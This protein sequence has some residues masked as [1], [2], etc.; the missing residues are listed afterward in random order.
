MDP[1][2]KTRSAWGVDQSLSEDT[3]NN[4]V[5]YLRALKRS[6]QGLPPDP[7]FPAPE[8]AAERRRNTR[9]KCEGSAEIYAGTSGVR[10]WASLTDLSRSGC[11]LELQATSP[12]ET[13]LVMSVELRG[14]RFRVKGI[15]RM[16]YPFLGMGVAFAEITPKD[17]ARLNELLLLLASTPTI[18]Q[19]EPAQAEPAIIVPDVSTVPDVQPV[20]QAV[21]SHFQTS[22]LMTREDFLTLLS[23]CR[24]PQ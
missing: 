15:V 23:R 6:N 14:I 8:P 3:G 2:W 24:A 12:V 21:A 7:I 4:A 20:L 18:P 1:D 10:T 16:S 22:A 19:I 5:E 17:E 11:Y 9:Y 13:P